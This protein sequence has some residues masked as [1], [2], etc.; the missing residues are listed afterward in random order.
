MVQHWIQQRGERLNYVSISSDGD[1][2]IHKSG[3]YEL[4][5]TI[6][7][8]GQYWG[9]L[10]IVNLGLS[11]PPGGCSSRQSFGQVLA[12]CHEGSAGHASVR[13]P[14]TSG[15]ARRRRHRPAVPV[16]VG[17]PELYV[18]TFSLVARVDAAECAALLAVSYSMLPHRELHEGVMAH[19][20]TDATFLEV[21]RLRH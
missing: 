19:N 2:L 12:S 21:Q 14:E 16:I 7:F 5:G 4:R 20:G 8:I 15:G 11:D 10:Y 13:L 9:A 1:I 6:T 3:I 17:E 18:C